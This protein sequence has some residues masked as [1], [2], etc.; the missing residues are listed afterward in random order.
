MEKF[1]FNFSDDLSVIKQRNSYTFYFEEFMK[2]DHKVMQ[3]NCVDKKRAE[4]FAQAARYYKEKHDLDICI[5]V[6]NNYLYMV[7]P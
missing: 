6:R 2:S 5:Y 7:K 1:E 4:R 3:I